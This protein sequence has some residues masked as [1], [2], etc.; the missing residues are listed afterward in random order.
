MK[1][2]LIKQFLNIEFFFH[3]QILNLKKCKNNFFLVF[4]STN[5]KEH[6]ALN[7]F[8]DVIYKILS[9]LSSRL[10][11]KI[12]GIDFAFFFFVFFCGALKEE[13]LKKSFSKQFLSFFSHF[14]YILH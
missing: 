10:I 9:D 5:S 13:S 6:R 7:T 14:F 8:V 11:E 12:R 4:L 1:I 3:F 2:Y